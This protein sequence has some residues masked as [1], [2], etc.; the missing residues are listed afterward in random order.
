MA[1]NNLFFDY[2]ELIKN[3]LEKLNWL[4]QDLK[5]YLSEK[6]GKSSKFALTDKELKEVYL[7]LSGLSKKSKFDLTNLS[8]DIN[9]LRKL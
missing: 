8:I 4:E 9:K 2:L 5:K 7:H 1:D 6:Y 3:K